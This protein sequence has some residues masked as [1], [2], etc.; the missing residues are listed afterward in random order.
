MV[1]TISDICVDVAALKFAASALLCTVEVDKF[2]CRFASPVVLLSI[3]TVEDLHDPRWVH[4]ILPNYPLVYP[5]V[6]QV[7]GSKFR[8]P[9]VATGSPCF[10]VTK[11]VVG[12]AHFGAYP[13][14]PHR[15]VSH[16]QEP[17]FAA[18]RCA[19]PLTLFRLPRLPRLP[20]TAPDAL[21]TLSTVG[22]SLGRV[23]GQNKS[24]GSRNV[25]SQ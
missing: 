21:A 3:A 12:D 8:Y 9:I 18:N 16:K 7:G 5:Y 4:K 15:G 23:P 1:M 6:T 25:V 13:P 19:Q 20:Q 17:D 10:P 2:R 11:V 24:N 22:Q 14:K